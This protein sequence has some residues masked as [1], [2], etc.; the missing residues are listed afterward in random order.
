MQL[1]A[2]PL[3]AHYTNGNEPCIVI[4]ARDAETTVTFGIID[5]NGIYR[6]AD[7]SLVR[8][9]RSRQNPYGFDLSAGIVIPTVTDS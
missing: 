9:A 8:F 2:I 1:F 6:E 7:A 4:G 5:A 3:A